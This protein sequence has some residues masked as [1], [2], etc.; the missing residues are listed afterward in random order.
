MPPL[1]KGLAEWDRMGYFARPER[2][3]NLP[4]TRYPRCKGGAR[5]DRVR[6]VVDALNDATFPNYARLSALLGGAGARPRRYCGTR[7]GRASD[8]ARTAGG[9]HLCG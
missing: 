3:E 2:S 8:R 7:G 9:T 1:L 4:S 5:G 6:A